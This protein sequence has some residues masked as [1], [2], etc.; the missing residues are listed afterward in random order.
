MSTFCE[1]NHVAG[2]QSIFPMQKL[3]RSSDT[4]ITYYMYMNKF[5]IRTTFLKNF[6]ISMALLSL[7]K[8]HLFKKK[9]T[10]QKLK[11]SSKINMY[12]V[13]LVN[14]TELQCSTTQFFTKILIILVKSELSNSC[15]YCI[16]FMSIK[17]FFGFLLVVL[18]KNTRKINSWKKHD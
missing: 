8:L 11:N 18:K 6:Q 16:L 13:E 4:Y 1:Q 3:P 12:I 7:V 17:L 10:F 5:Y 9:K 2:Y 14:Y 15:Y